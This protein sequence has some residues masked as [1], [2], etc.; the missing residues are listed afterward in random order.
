MRARSLLLVAVFGTTLLGADA[1]S[2]QLSPQGVIGA[3]T[4]PFRAVIGR[5]GHY[6]RHRYHAAN[7]VQPE[8]TPAGDRERHLGWV[9]TTAWT[10][11]Y[12]DVLGYAFWPADY[13]ARVRGRGFDIIADAVMRAPRPARVATTG[14][15]MV[16]QG[17]DV[18]QAADDWPGARIGQ[19]VLLNEAQHAALE[20]LKAAIAQSI[21][22]I[23][24]GCRETASLSPAARL[25]A[26]VQQL[27]A[28]RDA[29]IFIRAPL[30]DFYDSLSDV[31]KASFEMKPQETN[32]ESK[33]AKDAMGRQYQTCAAPG[34]QAAE[35]LTR[36]IEA[37]ARPNKSQDVSVE[38]L[39]KATSDMAKLLSAS[40]A[41]PI[42]ADPL[43]RLDAANN[44]LTSI[45][46]AAM[47]V[48]GA[49]NTL[50]AQLDN[51]QK[52]RLDSLGR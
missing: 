13:A 10:G 43:A 16:E 47:S 17:C 44:Q 6:P 50:T 21:A 28:V 23:K 45:N 15:A 25:D 33:A 31:Q 35:M 30:K 19:T 14:T 46:Y 32:T 26:M 2:A 51:E 3:F 29:G 4:R 7:Q 24:A 27:W 52:A 22:T 5:F 34:L 49:L 20:K 11:A 37:R 39:R 40:C 18:S 12:E 8:A 1:A 9:G 42:P 38:A 36:Q 48:G 41:Q